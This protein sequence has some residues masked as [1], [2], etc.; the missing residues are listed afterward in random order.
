ML[1]SDITLIKWTNGDKSVASGDNLTLSG[2]KP[3]ASGGKL[4]ES[5]VTRPESVTCQ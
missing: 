5:V 1:C 4:S 3:V 2:D